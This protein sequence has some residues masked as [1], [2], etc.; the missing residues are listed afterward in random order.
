MASICIKFTFVPS[1]CHLLRWK[2]YFSISVV[3]YL[4]VRIKQYSNPSLNKTIE[5]NIITWSSLNQ[6]KTVSEVCSSL[7]V[8]KLCFG[9]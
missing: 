1:L 5:R 3:N 7:H 8:Y 6:W 2:Y 9:Y 4:S